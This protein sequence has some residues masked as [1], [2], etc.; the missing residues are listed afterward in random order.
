[1]ALLEQ[2]KTFCSKN[3]IDYELFENEAASVAV[4]TGVAATST[5]P[6]RIVGAKK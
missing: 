5:A 1:M 4:F 2:V 3:G 6:E